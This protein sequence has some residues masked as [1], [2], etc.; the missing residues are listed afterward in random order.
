M[1]QAAR[2]SETSISSDRR[3]KLLG[4]DYT[5]SVM[6]EMLDLHGKLSGP[7]YKNLE[8]AR[9]ARNNW[10]HD[11]DAPSISDVSACQQA[12]K[13]LLARKGIHLSL[14]PGFRNAG[15]CWPLSIFHEV[16]GD[17]LPGFMSETEST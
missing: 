8:T 13:E 1:N 17:Q 9:K 15:A 12:I 14:Q 16:H 6:V 11:M 4:R 3:K 2:G 7:L 10:A 5:A